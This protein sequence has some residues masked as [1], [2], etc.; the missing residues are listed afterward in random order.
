[1]PC[2]TDYGPCNDNTEVQKLAEKV[3]MLTDLLCNLC[4]QF[5]E[6]GHK[7]DGYTANWYKLH[8]Q[9]DLKRKAREQ[10]EKVKQIAY[11]KRQIEELNKEIQ[12]LAGGK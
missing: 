3:D 7:M 5:E 9:V 10:A 12:E 4:S 6:T 2:H 11:K 8:Q 1:M